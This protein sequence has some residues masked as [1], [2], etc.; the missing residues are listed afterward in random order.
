MGHIEGAAGTAK[1]VD[2]QRGLVYGLLGAYAEAGAALARG[3]R[4][5]PEFKFNVLVEP[6]DGFKAK[7]TAATIFDVSQDQRPVFFQFRWDQSYQINPIWEMRGAVLADVH[8]DVTPDYVEGLLS[9]N[10]YF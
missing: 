10:R 3:W 1:F 9:L 2:S 6:V 4:A 8:P 5:G 7:L